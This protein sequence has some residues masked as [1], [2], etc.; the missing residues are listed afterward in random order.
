MCAAAVAVTGAVSAAYAAQL[1]NT[2]RR[3]SVWTPPVTYHRDPC[4]QC[5]RKVQTYGH[6]SCDGCGAPRG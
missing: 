5:G 6:I 1:Q 4:P 2:A 3:E